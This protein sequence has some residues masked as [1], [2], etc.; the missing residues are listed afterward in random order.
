MKTKRN[1]RNFDL[2]ETLIFYG[3]DTI[4]DIDIDTNM[5]IETSKN[6]K[7][8]IESSKKA[9]IR[10]GVIRLMK[11]SK[12]IGTPIIILS[13]H[14]KMEELSSILHA[15][16]NGNDNFFSSL[17]DEK[18][19]HYRSS[20]EEFVM[21]Y[22]EL[23]K[24]SSDSNTDENEYEY[25]YEPTFQGKGIG[26]APSPAAL[27]DA[28][29]T[30]LIEPRGF[31][32]SSGFGVK[33]ADAVRNPLPQHCVV[34]VSRESDDNPINC[35]SKSGGSESGSISRDR[36]I[37]SRTAG[38]RVM[39]VEGDNLGSCTAEDVSDGIVETLGT[40]D[41]W[42][43]VTMDD[44]STPGSFWLNMAV[45]KDENGDRVSAYDL[46]EY[47]DELRTIRESEVDA[48][49][50]KVQNG[51]GNANDVPVPDEMDEDE[52]ARILADMDSL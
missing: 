40:E 49:E 37:A 47:Y 5:D 23:L 44:I 25:E 46:I 12:D 42:E 48:D 9:K 21:N 27:I 6:T 4:L 45:P 33:H 52:I 31:G 15:S 7:I 26:Y 3:I 43:I 30:L 41:D 17:Y 14:L 11:E 10:P 18:V 36:C 16:S 28:V 20:L 38:M 8:D 24:S 22:D 2:P 35:K 1:L 13:E 34:F 19:L 29:N 32:G 50:D 39:Y 51:E